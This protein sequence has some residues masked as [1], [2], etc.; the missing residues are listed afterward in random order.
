VIRSSNL[1]ARFA[2]FFSQSFRYFA[3]LCLALPVVAQP[4][5]QQTPAAAFEP[6]V[7]PVHDEPHHR[8]IFQYGPT[9]ILDLQLPPGDRSWFH[10]HDW[11]VLYLTLSSAPMR[12]QVPGGEWTGGARRNDNAP[13]PAPPPAPRPTSFT[14]YFERPSTHRIEN[15]GDTLL[16]ALVVV[17]ETPGNDTLSIEQ[18]G[19]AGTPEVDNAW[20]RAYRLRLAGGAATQAHVHDAPVVLLQAT[21]GTAESSGPM[22]F[23][24]N[25]PGQWG[26][27][28]AGVEHAVR[29]VGATSL[30]L[31]E[32]EVRIR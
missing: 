23:E 29:N 14:G 18:A 15:T 16:R 32:V 20:F 1:G 31:I 8:Q 25:E 22:R 10:S 27:Y 9:R 13:R 4:Q 6:P 24:F 11:P 19:F 3:A 17:N 5:N 7:V 2:R 30:E 26:F 12:N 28:D 21:A